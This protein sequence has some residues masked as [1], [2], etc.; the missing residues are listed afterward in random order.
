[1]K[2]LTAH[3]LIASGELADPNFFRTVVLIF[4]HNEE[5]AA[6]VVLNRRMNATV[7][8]IWEQVSETP[9][10]CQASLHIGGPV[11]G[12]L[13]AL[14]GDEDLAEMSIFSGVY[15]STGRELLEKLVAER[16]DPLRFFVGYAGWSE[17]QLEK[18]LR[19]GSWLIAPATA[20]QVFGAVDDLWQQLT[21]SIVSRAFLS[22][23]NIKNVPPDVSLN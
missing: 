7:K 9:C 16:R 14:H 22:A 23:L 12:P 17:G 13:M 10:D 3:F 21:R 1:M 6:G 8:Q 19:D 4:R 18:E 15:L 2:S 11:E 5:G 20:E